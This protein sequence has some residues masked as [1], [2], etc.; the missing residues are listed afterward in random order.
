MRESTSRCTDKIVINYA[1][2]TNF[3]VTEKAKEINN[4]R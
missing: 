3:R 2:A 1:F 4:K